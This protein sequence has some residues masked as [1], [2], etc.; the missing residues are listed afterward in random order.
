MTKTPQEM[1]TEFHE[2]FGA[3]VGQSLSALSSDREA[4]RMGLIDEEYEELIA[5]V[6]DNDAVGIFDALGD[7]VYVIYGMAIE[8][9]GNLDAVVEEIHRSNMTKLDE[10]GN[11]ILRAD[12]KILKGS[13]YEPPNIAKSLGIEG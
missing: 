11:P 2:A 7:M 9:G 4:L 3:P 5:A 10:D 6:K 13:N 1:V 12:G 8:M